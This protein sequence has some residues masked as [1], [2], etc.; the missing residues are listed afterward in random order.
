[1]TG[2][3]LRYETEVANLLG[4]DRANCEAARRAAAEQLAG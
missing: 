3:S 2:G 4:T 1:M